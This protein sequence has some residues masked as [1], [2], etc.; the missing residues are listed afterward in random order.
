PPR[1]VLFL[2]FLICIAAFAACRNASGPGTVNVT[3][4]DRSIKPDRASM[5]PGNVTFEVSNKGK[6]DHELILVRTDFASDKLPV[7]TADGGK[8][9]K[10]DVDLTRAGVMSVGD[11]TDIAPGARSTKIFSVAKGKYAL[12]CNI[13]GH[14]SDGMYTAFVVQ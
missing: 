6:V 3:L 2:A 7:L 4:D 5:S 10:G 9:K 12:I 1:G 11:V 13:P 14:Y 8:H